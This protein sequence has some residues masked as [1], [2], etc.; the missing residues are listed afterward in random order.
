MDSVAA[1]TY[2]LGGISVAGSLLLLAYH[3]GRLSV[4]VERLEEDRQRFER[5][6]NAMHSSLR[7]V[8]SMMRGEAT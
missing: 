1:A 2:V 6:F 8:E 7:R 3:I 4:R 5:Q